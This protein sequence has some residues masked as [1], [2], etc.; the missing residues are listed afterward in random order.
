MTT[1]WV[2]YR[3]AGKWQYESSH[4]PRRKD[5]ERILRLR[6][7]DTAKGIPVTSDIGRLRFEEARDDL[8][9][10]H[11]ANGR[12]TTKM[13]ARIKKHLTPYFTKIKMI[14]ITIPRINAYI[15]KRRG[16]V[17][18]LPAHEADAQRNNLDPR[19]AKAG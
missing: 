17:V 18:L 1:G 3:S 19:S 15:A 2:K 16:D 10:F 13:E 4:S 6:E 12:D 11:K 8:I 5:A 7:G 14:D 9:N